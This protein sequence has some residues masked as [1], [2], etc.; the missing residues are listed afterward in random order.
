MTERSFIHSLGRGVKLF[1]RLLEEIFTTSSLT[2]PDH[3][4]Y[5]NLDFHY[6]MMNKYS[7]AFAKYH[8]RSWSILVRPHPAIPKAK[9]RKNSYYG[10]P[11]INN[12]ILISQILACRHVTRLNQGLSALAPRGGKMRDPGNEVEFADA[13]RPRSIYQNSNM[14]PGLSGQNCKIAKFLLFL[15]SQ[16]RLGCEE[17]NTRYRSLS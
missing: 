5:S 4:T 2:E 17:S 12:L 6:Q 14:A 15:N 7:S 13:N 9:H 16:K 1:S 3:T 11:S 10:A 8:R